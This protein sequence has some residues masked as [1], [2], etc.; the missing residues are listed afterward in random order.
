MMKAAEGQIAGRC[1]RMEVRV[2]MEV[3]RYMHRGIC[4]G[5]STF[6]VTQCKGSVR[7]EIKQ[8]SLI[9]KQAGFVI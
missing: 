1:T 8:R 3:Q 6:H 9:A 5:K 7:R 2:E 4:I